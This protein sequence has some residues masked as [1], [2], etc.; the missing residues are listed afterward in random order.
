M[1]GDGHHYDVTSKCCGVTITTRLIERKL[2]FS[3]INVVFYFEEL[4]GFYQNTD[5][6]HIK[7]GI[8]KN[9][10]GGRHCT[11]KSPLGRWGGFI[12]THREPQTPPFQ[13]CPH[14][15]CAAFTWQISQISKTFWDVFSIKQT[16]AT[17]SERCQNNKITKNR[18]ILCFETIRQKNRKLCNFWMDACQMHDIY[19]VAEN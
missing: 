7:C 9:G 6:T 14:V 17:P 4:L 19:D 10:M 8:K 15:W 2:F 11:I 12:C 3:E 1:R 18:N 5:F 13:H 16:K